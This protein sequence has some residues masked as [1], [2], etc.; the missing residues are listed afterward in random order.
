MYAESFNPIRIAV[1]FIVIWDAFENRDY[2]N[3]YL[4]RDAAA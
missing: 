3:D 4:M 2:W 1:P